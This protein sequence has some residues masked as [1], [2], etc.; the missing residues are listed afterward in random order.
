MRLRARFNRAVHDGRDE[1]IAPD[2]D[3]YDIGILVV[4]NLADFVARELLD[5]V[6]AMLP[7]LA[8]DGLRDP[9][10]RRPYLRQTRR[11]RLWTT[12]TVRVPAPPD[13]G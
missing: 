9:Q 5:E 10:R 11:S 7:S 8:R 13:R 2:S 3:G 1:F 12:L 6:Q 4:I